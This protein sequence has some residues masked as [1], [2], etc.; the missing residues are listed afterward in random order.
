MIFFS[1]SSSVHVGVSH[2]F[3]TY[4]NKYDFKLIKK[5]KKKETEKVNLSSLYLIQRRNHLVCGIGDCWF[6][7]NKS[8]DWR[9]IGKPHSRSPEERLY[10]RSKQ[11]RLL[12]L[13]RYN[14]QIKVNKGMTS[15]T[16]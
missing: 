15:E 3:S 1:P 6:D 13:L 5:K 8:W 14:C 9:G 11:I 4:P 10:R 16:K 2:T 7:L 12:N